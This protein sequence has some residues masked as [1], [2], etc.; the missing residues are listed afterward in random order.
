MHA[1]I[2]FPRRLPQQ[3]YPEFF[4]K[5]DDYCAIYGDAPTDDSVIFSAWYTS[6]VRQAHT[7]AI[8][9]NV[10]PLQSSSRG[11][12]T[13]P[14]TTTQGRAVADSFRD[15]QALDRHADMASWAAWHIGDYVAF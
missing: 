6:S 2:S 5:G 8:L 13:T 3:A 1:H 9:G 7:D 12:T 14:P 10:V 11:M 15:L 4:E